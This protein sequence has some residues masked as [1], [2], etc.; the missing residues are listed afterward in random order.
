MAHAKPTSNKRSRES[1]KTKEE[2]LRPSELALREAHAQVARSGERWW[3]VFENSIIGFALTDL[4]GQFI[5]TNPAYQRMVGYTDEE[6]QQCRFLDITVEEYREHDWALVEELLGGKRRQFQIEKQF[7]RKDGSLVWVRNSVSIVPSNEKSPRF[8]M[9]LS[10]DITNARQIS[11]IS[12]EPS[13]ICS[14]A[15][16]SSPMASASAKPAHFRGR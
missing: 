7:R 12:S 3:S 1:S 9:A 4:K 10:E 14:A 2:K 16:R 13:S 15:N 6:L 8:I 5:A 11:M